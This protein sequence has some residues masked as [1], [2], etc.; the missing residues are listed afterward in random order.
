MNQWQNEVYALYTEA[1]KFQAGEVHPE[2]GSI[3]TKFRAAGH[4]AATRDAAH[5][6]IS[7]LGKLGVLSEEEVASVIR[8]NNLASKRQTMIDLLGKY[9]KEIGGRAQEITDTIGAEFDKFAKRE[10]INRGRGATGRQ[11]KYQS[12]ALAIELAKQQ[13]AQLKQ[14]KQVAKAPAADALDVLS[15][16]LDNAEHELVGSMKASYE[17]PT[18]IFELQLSDRRSADRVYN[19][20]LPYAGD[21]E[22]EVNGN[23][24]E[25]SASPD[26]DLVKL[27]AAV[28]ADKVKRT[29]ESEIEKIAGDNVVVIIEPDSPQDAK[30]L[31]KNIMGRPRKDSTDTTVS[32]Y[33][34]D[35]PPAEDVNS[36][37][38]G[39]ENEENSEG[40]T[41]RTA[42]K[43]S[44]EIWDA[45]KKKWDARKARWDKFKSGRAA[46]RGEENSEHVRLD[47]REHP[48]ME[49]QYDPDDYYPTHKGGDEFGPCPRCG[50]EMEIGD[51][52]EDERCCDDCAVEEMSRYETEEKPF[53]YNFNQPTRKRRSSFDENEE[54]RHSPQEVNRKMNQERSLRMQNFLKQNEKWGN[55]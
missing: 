34:Q 25:F 47:P 30:N 54:T 15:V 21:A 16:G 46:K 23:T 14:M 35:R 10:A 3:P 18:T 31:V 19:F 4:K 1:R 8:N 42:H 37:D 7:F 43:S 44:A 40:S 32:G 28:G 33:S 27:I 48:G 20:I 13:S 9:S 2:F 52:G 39:A 36:W 24:V 51:E 41:K 53:G 45:N 6:I 11:D 22:V 12:N 55:Y 26:S 50:C 49:T 17:D 38:Y 5:F 29:L